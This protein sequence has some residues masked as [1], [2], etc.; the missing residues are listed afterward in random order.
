MTLRVAIAGAGLGGLCL[1]QGLRR[2]GV[3]AVVFERDG[4]LGERRQGYRLHLDARA[5]LALE[6]CLENPGRGSHAP[7]AFC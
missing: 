7:A 6:K 1:A 3:E 5:G 2:A 4:S